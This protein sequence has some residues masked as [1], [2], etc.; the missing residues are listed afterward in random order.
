M[1]HDPPDDTIHVMFYP[2]AIKI[3][4]IKSKII[5]SGH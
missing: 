5:E 4:P 2:Q 3:Y 1:N